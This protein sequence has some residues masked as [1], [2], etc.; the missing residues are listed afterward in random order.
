MSVARQTAFPYQPYESYSGFSL[1]DT[2]AEKSQLY[3]FVTNPEHRD[4]SDRT[5]HAP[6]QQAAP[7]LPLSGQFVIPEIAQPVQSLPAP[8][9]L[10]PSLYLPEAVNYAALLFRKVVLR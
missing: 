5:I 4:T 10:I 2:M 9:P 8:S 7:Q 6:R 1:P 3:S